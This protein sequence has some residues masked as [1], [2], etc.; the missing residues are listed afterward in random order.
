MN[1]NKAREILDS[2]FNGEQPALAGEAREHLRECAACREWHA[3]MSQT[4]DLLNSATEPSAPDIRSMV[5]RDLPA[6]HPAAARAQA[7]G[8]SVWRALAWLAACW[9]VSVLILVPVLAAALRWLSLSSILKAYSFG[10]TIAGAFGGFLVAGR[11]V[12]HVAGHCAEGLALAAVGFGPVLMLILVINVTLFGAV[13]F[14]WR[15]R[16][17]TTSACLI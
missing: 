14:A 17:G 9:M 12:V 2:V 15:R 7:S 4:L 6:V 8:R 5:M 10:K 13:V 16:P 3:S 11:A 1:C